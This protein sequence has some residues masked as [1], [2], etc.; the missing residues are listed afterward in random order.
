MG[1]W[2][3]PLA[4]LA[5]AV[6]LGLTTLPAVP[7]SAQATVQAAAPR[8]AVTL[9]VSRVGVTVGTNVVVSGAV[10]PARR[11][12]R[13]RV[14]RR[15]G[16]S[17]ETVGSTTTRAGGAYTLRGVRATEVGNF[18]YRALVR[19]AGRN[20]SSRY[21]LLV[22]HPKNR[23]T[24]VSGFVHS[25]GPIR[26]ATVRVYFPGRKAALRTVRTNRWGY[27]VAEVP[28]IPQ[29]LHVTATGGR[30][31]VGQFGGTM[32]A[33]VVDPSATDAFYVNPATTLASRYQDRHPGTSAATAW[34]RIRGVLGLTARHNLQDALGARPAYFDGVRFLQQARRS[35]G[36]D[37]YVARLV[38]QAGKPAARGARQAVDAASAPVFAARMAADKPSFVAGL[39]GEEAAGYLSVASQAAGV[40]TAVIG[41]TTFIGAL[42]GWQPGGDPNAE[43]LDAIAEV[44]GTLNDISAQIN[45]LSATVQAD[46]NA[47]KKTEDLAA[48]NAAAKDLETAYEQVNLAR[49]RMQGYLAARVPAPAATGA[50]DTSN[51]AQT[52]LQLFALAVQAL[53]TSFG[54]ETDHFHDAVRPDGADETP[55]LNFYV[56]RI[57]DQSSNVF[58]PAGSAMVESWTQKVLS[59][60]AVAY[61]LV[62]MYERPLDPGK[63]TPG[64]MIDSTST[65]Y[66]GSS[67]ATYPQ[68]ADKTEVPTTPTDIPTSG[69]LSDMMSY[70]QG[71]LPVPSKAAVMDDRMYLRTGRMPLADFMPV[72]EA[73]RASCGGVLDY[74]T[75]YR[76]YPVGVRDGAA[77]GKDSEVCTALADPL[78]LFDLAM[79]EYVS[80]QSTAVVADM[81]DGQPETTYWG[82]LYSGW[83]PVNKDALAAVIHP[84]YA[85]P[86]GSDSWFD[87]GPVDFPSSNDYYVDPEYD[88]CADQTAP[89]E[90]CTTPPDG[91]IYVEDVIDSL[92]L[93]YRIEDGSVGTCNWAVGLSAGIG[94]ACTNTWPMLIGRDLADGEKYVPDH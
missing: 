53:E 26:G 48:Y 28:R 21:D 30:S 74:N 16:R 59:Q 60:Q 88:V 34:R 6:G 61:Y 66:L 24:L 58:L 47:L 15:A 90:G 68:Y 57:L 77:P 72:D 33:D 25:G 22:V 40:V 82:N 3:R 49:T 63:P 41:V 89:V 11:G 10:T 92:V 78:R 81:I 1:T 44:Q 7:A 83:E 19:S 45:T 31:P 86:W 80:E 39:I 55:A 85:A 54:D 38:R 27:F 32:L 14:E 70:L 43:V 50:G 17:W 94:N 69:N 87:W 67:Y 2:F 20:V 75:G 51:D 23:A 71:L 18:H 8:P 52:K 4:M 35:G 42:A 29:R 84:L 56:D 65:S 46:Y 64:L 62:M 12:V 76:D 79:A 9:D 13:V 5:V 93:H 36:F 73:S 37:K 91:P